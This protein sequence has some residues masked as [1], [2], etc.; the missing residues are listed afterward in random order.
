MSVTVKII[1]I[2]TLQLE[3]IVVLLSLTSCTGQRKK[4]NDDTV[5][6]QCSKGQWKKKR[7]KWRSWWENSFSRPTVVQFLY[8]VTPHRSAHRYSKLQLQMLNQTVMITTNKPK[9]CLWGWGSKAI[10]ALLWFL[11]KYLEKNNFFYTTMTGLLQTRTNS[12]LNLYN[13]YTQ[14]RFN[15][16]AV[17]FVFHCWNGLF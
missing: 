6:D 15:S 5:R 8:L 17:S 12:I 3:V 9:P 1:H 16:S 14:S 7:T 10:M 11:N 13:L 4:H 2:I